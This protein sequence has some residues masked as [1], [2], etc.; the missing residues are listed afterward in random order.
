[1]DVC[2]D[3]FGNSSCEEVPDDNA[4]IVAANSQQGSP[5]VEGARE[6]HAD[7][8]QSAIRLLQTITFILQIT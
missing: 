6:R 1:M 2:T 4:A 3:N 5:A 7:T 8:V